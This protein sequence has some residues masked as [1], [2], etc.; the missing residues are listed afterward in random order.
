[1]HYSM[2][3]DVLIRPV[4]EAD[5][6]SIQAV[7]LE[8]WQYTYHNIFDEQFIEKFVNQNYAP[9]ATMALFPYL[10]AGTICFDVAEYESRVIGYCHI[11]IHEQTAQLY[12]IYLLPA[13]IGQGIGKKLLRRGES[14]LLGHRINTYSC[15][16]HQ[17]NEI[18]K[19]FYSRA[20]FQHIPEKD[21]DDEWYMQKR[22]ADFSE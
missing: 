21:R 8:A 17:D 3:D 12:R 1:M 11:G 20:G 13:Y 22:I 5:L 19:R 15:F 9:E 18:G 6:Q 10:Q 4:R 16:V 14:F 7:A 2:P